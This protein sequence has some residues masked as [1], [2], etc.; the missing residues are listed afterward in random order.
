MRRVF[1]RNTNL[2]K[3][4]TWVAASFVKDHHRAG[5]PSRFGSSTC[6]GLETKDGELVAVAIFC[7]PRTS[8]TK[9]KYA[10]ELLRLCFKDDVRVP[11]GASKLI[12]HFLKEKDPDNLFTYQDT[13]GESTDV[14][15]K[16]GMV[17]VSKHDPQ[18]RVIVKN[19]LTYT[20]A[21]NN[22]EDWFSI[23]Q[24]AR[25]G[26]DAL[27]GS[28]LGEQFKPDGKRYSN[29]ELFEKFLDYHIEII[30]GDRIYEWHNPNR[31]Y[32]TYKI[33][34]SDSEKYFIGKSKLTMPYKGNVE[35]NVSLDDLLIDGYLGSGGVEFQNWKTKHEGT[36]TKE[37]LGVYRTWGE[38]VEAE[39][40]LVGKCRA[41]DPNCLNSAS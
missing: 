36:L 34:A 7:K 17:L 19:G 32:F 6:Y 27:V 26:P 16:C 4:P 38:V 41:T 31:V 24:V 25:R 20:T 15:E 12:F 29:I 9:K 5:M 8:G 18:K 39:K 11:G 3:L 30:P 22:R 33:T 14:Y 21:S 28:T 10:E 13:S 1:A 40:K 37:I 35:D 23:E 2:V